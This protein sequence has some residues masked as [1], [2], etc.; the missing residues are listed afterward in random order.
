MP[1]P[2]LLLR[3]TPPP[4]PGLSARADVALFVGL[5][6]R[7]T[8]MPVPPA[9][10]VRL[11]QA[12][13]AGLGP[14]ARGPSAVEALL[15]VP[16]PLD[17]WGEF[18]AL[19]AWD[20]RIVR[21]GAPDRMPCALGLAVRSFFEAG[22]A[23]AYVVRTGDPLPLLPAGPAAGI[24]TAKRRLLDWAAS[25]PP[26]SPGHRVPLLPGFGPGSPPQATDPGTWRGVAHV[27]GVDDAAMLSLPDLPELFSGAPM[28]LPAIPTPPPVPEAF[29]PCAP[30]VPGYEPPLRAERPAIAAA[31]LGRSGYR[32]WARGL[33]HVLDLL[34]TPRGSAHRRDVMLVASLPLP[35]LVA[36][37]AAPE[38]WPL[39]MLDRSGVPQPGERLT[40]PHNLGSARLQLAW[41][42]IETDAS[43]AMPEGIEGAEGVL[44]GA[45]ARTALRLGA[46]RSAAGTSLPTVHR[47]LPDIGTGALRRGLPDGRADW[48]GDRLSVIGRRVDGHVLLSDATMSADRIWRSAGVSR[49]MGIIQRAARGLAQDLLF[50]PAGQA[51][52]NT[53]RSDLERFMERLRQAG[54]LDG[55]TVDQ[56][57]TVRC[58]HSTMTQSDIDNGRTVVSIAFTAA[59]PIQRITVTLAVGS[60]GDIAAREAA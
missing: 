5:V 43:G 16:V 27:L 17:S 3:Q 28:P 55:A 60:Q 31:R 48:L 20:Q 25:A 51:L 18:E 49:L 36:S 46:F 4:P 37:P 2:E 29:R 19:F 9:L 24:I 52:W 59:Q 56:A 1:F 7:R 42:W 34:A 50:E 23:R 53:I 13:W 12:G 10:R 21:P 40:D 14:F 41:P 22:G 38:T 11:E 44:M 47:I 32:D 26:P 57:Y 6:P 8:G 35:A 54:A 15:D 33:R 30:A 39:A 45:I 58:D